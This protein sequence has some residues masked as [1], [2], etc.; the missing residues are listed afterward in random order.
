MNARL[1]S[2]RPPIALAGAA[3][4]TLDG[5]AFPRFVTELVNSVFKGLID[6]NAQQIRAYVDM[7]SGVTQASAD[8]AAATGPDQARAWLVQQFPDSYDLGPSTDDWGAEDENG[9]TVVGL[10]EE[11]DGPPR[12]DVAM[13]L[14]LEGE[15]A[16]GSDTE[17]P[18]EELLCKVRA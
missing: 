17:A 11:R 18:E 2:T 10:R 4:D 7:N 1:I 5:I 9:T 3:R 14:E 13:L 15:A 16:E 12:E 6:A 8:S